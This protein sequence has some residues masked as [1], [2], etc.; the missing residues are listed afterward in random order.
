MY[1]VGAAMMAGQ[2]L[3]QERQWFAHSVFLLM[4]NASLDKAGEDGQPPRQFFMPQERVAEMLWGEATPA[5]EKKV[6]SAVE[7]LRAAGLLRVLKRGGN[8]RTARYEL[9]FEPVDIVIEAAE[10]AAQKAAKAPRIAASNAKAKATR[11]AKRAAEAADEAA[12]A[13][14]AAI[15]DTIALPEVGGPSR[16]PNEDDVREVG[17]PSRTPSGGVLGTPS[18]GPLGTK[19]GVPEGPPLRRRGKKRI[20]RLGEENNSPE[21][22]T[23]PAAVDERGEND[24]DPELTAAKIELERLGAGR[25]EALMA[26]AHA[27]GHTST[28]DMILNAA[29]RIAA[30]QRTSSSWD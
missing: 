4:A 13:E 16:I 6:Q 3:A 9:L 7:T 30:G 23:S 14:V 27:D 17:G 12:L 24:D 18:G 26:R 28:R 10:Y 20:R 21:V 22:S 29:S 15:V 2:V 8:G 1:N 11:A 19:L 25:Y 5:R